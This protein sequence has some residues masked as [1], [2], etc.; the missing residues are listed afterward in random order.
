[1]VL[2]WN[3]DPAYINEIVKDSVSCL[4]PSPPKKP[5]QH[6][7]KPNQQTNQKPNKQTNPTIGEREKGD[8]ERNAE[9][10]L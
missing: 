7:Q 1:M 10:D 3:A 2:G 5:N 8:V 6:N 9:F 4:H